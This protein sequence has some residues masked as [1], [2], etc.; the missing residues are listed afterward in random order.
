MQSNGGEILIG[1]D[2]SKGWIDVCRSGTTRVERIANNPE[3]LAAWVARARPT[4]LGMEPTGGYE[5][6]LCSAL[7]EAGVR[8][9]K[10]H[11]NAILAF[12]KAWRPSAPRPIG[13]TRR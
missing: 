2:V 1:A 10:L 4:L 5:R 9:V 3:A 8:S 7:A 12:R 13:S 6:A 11:P